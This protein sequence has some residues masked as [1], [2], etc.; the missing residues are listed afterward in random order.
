MGNERKMTVRR[1]SFSPEEDAILQ[2]KAQTVGMTVSGYIRRQALDGS[3]ISIDWN[4]LQQHTQAINDMTAT[5]EA[6]TQNRK[7]NSL[8]Y[9]TDLELIHKRLDEVISLEVRLLAEIT[10]CA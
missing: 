9:I 7:T 5:F 1:I 6:Y 2:N 10:R 8:L 3:V 4:K